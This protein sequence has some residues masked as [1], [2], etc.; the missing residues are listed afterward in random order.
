MFTLSLLPWTLSYQSIF[1]CS[2]SHYYSQFQLSSNYTADQL[3]KYRVTGFSR[4]SRFVRE[5]SGFHVWYLAIA[6]ISHFFPIPPN[7]SLIAKTIENYRDLVFAH[8]PKSSIDSKMFLSFLIFSLWLR[9]LPPSSLVMNPLM[10][11]ARHTKTARQPP[12]VTPS[13]FHLVR[14]GGVITLSFH[15]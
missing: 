11:G 12:T 9:V 6:Y 3:D 4:S 10:A 2:L 8:Y 5:S 7:L 15:E 1:S 13:R 14:G